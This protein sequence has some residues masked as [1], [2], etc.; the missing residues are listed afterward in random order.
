MSSD[1]ADRA[2]TRR[3]GRAVATLLA[4]TG[5]AAIAPEVHAQC[6]LCKTQAE[7]SGY[8]NAINLGILVLLVPTLAL[9]AGI[10]YRAYR[11]R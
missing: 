8:G 4:I 7:G 10:L 9:F 3:L 11:H 6:V 2:G 1:C 5:A